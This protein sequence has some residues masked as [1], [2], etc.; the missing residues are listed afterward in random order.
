M[1]QRRIRAC[2]LALAVAL[3]LV[4][5]TAAVA[6]QNQ[7]SST[8]QP[9]A[10]QKTYYGKIEKLQNGKYGLIVDAKKSRGY[11]LDNQKAAAKFARKNVLV[12]GKVDPKTSV[13]HIVKIE[14]A[15]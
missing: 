3:S 12:T 4:P 8:Q 10:P 15:S 2:A 6:A 7:K 5:L 1:K 14:P 9:A 11:F 13:L